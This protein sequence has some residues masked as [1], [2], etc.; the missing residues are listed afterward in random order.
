M[1]P[2]GRVWVVQVDPPLVV[3]STTPP[4]VLDAVA[5]QTLAESQTISSIASIPEGSVWGVQV[6]PPFVVPSMVAVVTLPA[7]SDADAASHTE[8]VAHPTAPKEPSVLS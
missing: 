8:V 2:L 5:S 6:V 4:L 7:P 1:T 3:P